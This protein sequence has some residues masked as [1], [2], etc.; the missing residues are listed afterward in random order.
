ME[1]FYGWY[2]K[3]ELIA[4]QKNK[5]GQ[6]KLEVVNKSF[7]KL[8]NKLTENSSDNSIWNVLIPLLI[9]AGLTLLTQFLIELWKS[10][11]E[12]KLKKQE[13]ISKAKAKTY[14]IAQIIKDLAMF[15]TQKQYYIRAYRLAKQRNDTEEYKDNY[16]KHY[17]KAN[18]LRSVETKLDESIAEYI[19]IVSEYIILTK[20]K[21]NFE[22]YFQFLFN[23]NHPKALKFENCNNED[24]L[25]A[26]HSIEEKRLNGEYLNL[27]QALHNIQDLM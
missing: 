16:Q 14:L 25:I 22:E 5:M 10:K 17:D 3:L 9:G 8:V 20:S 6:S 13:L 1:P 18:N 26:E 27:N 21:E 15:K 19:Q 12:S 11:K 24:E 7:D 4:N 23:Y 2:N